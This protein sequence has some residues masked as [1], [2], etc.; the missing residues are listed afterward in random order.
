MSIVEKK[1]CGGD[2]KEQKKMINEPKFNLRDL[3]NYSDE[4]LK[5]FLLQ[6]KSRED[7]AYQI[8]CR[9]AA[10]RAA[11]QVKIFCE[12]AK[13]QREIKNELKRRGSSSK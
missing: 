8:F 4:E 10:S 13:N 6:E 9:C 12:A 5:H 11:A 7:Q 3:I 2:M 1:M